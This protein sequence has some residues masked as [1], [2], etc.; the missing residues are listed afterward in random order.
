M[1]APSR[2]EVTKLAGALGLDDAGRA[3]LV[4]AIRSQ[5]EIDD[6]TGRMGPALER[7]KIAVI[8][9]HGTY[10]VSK[11]KLAQVLGISQTTTGNIT[12]SAQAR[13][14]SDPVS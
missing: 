5:R 13:A 1:T 11:Y 3:L 12:R 7:R 4:E 9:L 2:A 14:E 8:G 10:R 6:L